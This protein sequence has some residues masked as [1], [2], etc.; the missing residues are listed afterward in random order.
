MKKLFKKTILAAMLIL[1]MTFA[2]PQQANA[3]NI[4]T[5]VV[6]ATIN[7]SKIDDNPLRKHVY[8][9]KLEWRHDPVTNT[10]WLLV[11]YYEDGVCFKIE[12]YKA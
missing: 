9:K 8:E 12:I 6:G 10:D 1:S 11:K 4:Y 2:A 5:D 3:N 7:P